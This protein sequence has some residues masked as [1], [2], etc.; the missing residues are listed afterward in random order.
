[1]SDAPPDADLLPLSMY[2][3]EPA[4]RGMRLARGPDLPSHKQPAAAPW[5][6]RPTRSLGQLLP[7]V[8]ALLQ[9][10]RCADE[11]AAAEREK[12]A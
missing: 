4:A 8:L 9:A 2:D 3:D 7:E 6:W 11:L 1:M 10:E 5:P 12:A